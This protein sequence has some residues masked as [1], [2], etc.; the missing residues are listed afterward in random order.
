[1]MRGPAAR[2]PCAGTIQSVQFMVGGVGI[3]LVFYVLLCY[4]LAYACA[5]CSLMPAAQAYGPK[6][7]GTRAVPAAS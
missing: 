6:P 3:V 5:A 2:S 4:G 7:G 1:M